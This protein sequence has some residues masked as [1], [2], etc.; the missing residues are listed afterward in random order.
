M[1]FLAL[2]L[3]VSENAHSHTVYIKEHSVREHSEDKPAGRTLFVL[4][5]PPYIDE[6][7]L[8]NA[9]SEIGNIYSISFME[10][11][12]LAA[13]CQLVNF[14]QKPTLLTFRVA[15]IVFNK[16]SDLNKVLLLKKLRPVNREESPIKCGMKKW[17]DEYNNSILSAKTLKDSID[18]F[19]KEHDEKIKLAEE[20]EKQLENADKDGWV[21]VTK[22]GKGTKHGVSRIEKAENKLMAKEEGTMK[23]KLELKNFYTFQIRESKMKHIVSLRQKFEEDKRK[24]AQIKQSRRF[25]P[26]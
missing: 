19:M 2:Q 9:F 23:K 4:N 7:G 20:K 25:K 14:I 13:K 1:F 17:I 10:T 24:I 12:S 8:T 6:T 16:V 26:F 22:K 18:T 21:T 15:Y 3:K 11:P 5:V